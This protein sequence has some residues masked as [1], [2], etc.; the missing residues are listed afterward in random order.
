M[1]P[2]HIWDCNPNDKG[3]PQVFRLLEQINLGKNG[4]GMHTLN[5]HGG[6]KQRWHELDFLVVSQRAILGI[7]V[8]AGE[9]RCHDGVWHIYRKDGS[10]AYSKHKSPLVQASE[11]LDYFRTKWLRDRFDKRFERVPFVKVSILCS[12]HRPDPIHNPMGPELPDKLTAYSEDLSPDGLKQ[13]LN[14]AIDYEIKTA[15]RN[16]SQTL[17]LEDCDDL[18]GSIRP[19]L[20]K[21]YPSRAAMGHSQARQDELT[22]EQYKSADM[23]DVTMRYIM[24]G[25]AGTGKTF[26]MLYDAKRRASRGENVGVLVPHESLAEHLRSLSGGVQCFTPLSEETANYPFDVLYVD[27]AQDFVN[28]TGFDLMDRLVKG[29]MESGNWRI[30]GDFENQLSPTNKIEKDIWDVLVECTGNRSIFQLHRNVR[31]T[32]AIVKW[33]ELTCGARVGQTDSLGAGPDVEVIS[34]I[35]FWGLLKG[36]EAHS[37]FGE[38]RFDDVVVLYPSEIDS[39]DLTKLK[40]E[41]KNKC[42]VSSIEEFRGLESPVIYIRGLDSIQDLGAL[43]DQAYK[44]VSRARSLC[45]I[46]GG[47]RTLN[48]F[49]DLVRCSRG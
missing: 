34:S 20:D 22:E 29:G 18:K 10:I 11:A 43:K 2:S 4:Y 25:G 24:D 46:E 44:A 3:E 45:L 16:N 19:S 8:K 40:M 33:L 47:E 49:S 12:N 36:G 9:V 26:L 17:T 27:E 28:E 41:F 5:L 48:N 39:T 42:K 38:I 31:N 6:K 23:I 35:E 7:E 1:I 30:Y 37:V 13:F 14:D 15:P 32:P 21:S